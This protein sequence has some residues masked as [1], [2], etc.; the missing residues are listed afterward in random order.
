MSNTIKEDKMTPV[1]IDFTQRNSIDESWL[2]MFGE[3]I[4]MILKAMFGGIDIPLRVKGSSSDVRAFVTAMGREKRYI[5]ALRQYGLDNPRT[6]RSKAEL[7]KS[8]AE[9]QRKTGI[10]WPYK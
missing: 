2:K 10:K 9:F 3:Q 5:E 4:K 8:T 1:V 7:A 6:Y